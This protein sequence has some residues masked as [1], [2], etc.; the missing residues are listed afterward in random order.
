M[1]NAAFVRV[2][3]SLRRLQSVRILKNKRRGFIEDVFSGREELQIVIGRLQG[4]QLGRGGQFGRS[5]T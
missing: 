4:L 2:E 1:R 5:L 3:R